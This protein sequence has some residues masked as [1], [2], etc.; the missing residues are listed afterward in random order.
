MPS[1]IMTYFKK[2]RTRA[3]YER[4]ADGNPLRHSGNNEGTPFYWGSEGFPSHEEAQKIPLIEQVYNIP[5][6]YLKLRKASVIDQILRNDPV[7]FNTDVIYAI[8]EA[9]SPICNATFDYMLK[10]FEVFKSSFIYGPGDFRMYYCGHCKE[11]SPQPFINFEHIPY[12]PKPQMEA[13]VQQR[14]RYRT[15]IYLKEKTEGTIK[16]ID[17]VCRKC[18]QSTPATMVFGVPDSPQGIELYKHHQVVDNYP[19]IQ[20]MYNTVQVTCFYGKIQFKNISSMYVFNVKTGRS[21]AMPVLRDNKKIDNKYNSMVNFT[22]GHHTPRV[23]DLHPNSAPFQDLYAA[24]SK[25]IPFGKNFA[26]MHRDAIRRPTSFTFSL[27]YFALANRFFN[28]NRPHDTRFILTAPAREKRLLSKVPRNW[29]ETIC[30]V[31]K[32]LPKQKPVRQAFYNGELGLN[33]LPRMFRWKKLITDP[34]LLVRVLSNEAVASILDSDVYYT[35]DVVRQEKSRRI[36]FLEALIAFHGQATTVKKLEQ[37]LGS[38]QRQVNN[39]FGEVTFEAEVSPQLFSDT[40]SMY[41]KLLQYNVPIPMKGSIEDMHALY[42]YVLNNIEK[43][44]RLFHF[45]EEINNFSGECAGYTFELGK[46]TNYLRA[47]GRAMNICVGGYDYQVERGHCFIVTVRKDNDLYACLEIRNS[48]HV[49]RLHAEKY[50]LVQAKHAYNRPL[51]EKFSSIV[52]AW[53]KR[54][55]IGYDQNN[56]DM[57]SKD[58]DIDRAEP[59]RFYYK[60]VEMKGQSIQQQILTLLGKG[61]PPIAPANIL[62][63]LYPQQDDYYDEDEDNNHLNPDVED[64]V[65]ILPDDRIL[66]F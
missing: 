13:E 58:D 33:S 61:N 50:Q 24:M 4:G 29:Q 41:Y 21:Y 11:A 40:A 17:Y 56:Y 66:P 3:S 18:G 49:A 57:F 22:F 31:H 60:E 38:L 44:N 63:N 62:N 9:L 46:S 51:S 14:G 25:Y 39:E 6:S 64:L 52:R 2:I 55:D 43:E 34:H 19:K 65:D 15:R 10:P 27:N 20:F 35:A 32:A 23:L 7:R 12:V 48:S 26:N 30:Y 5:E 54:R 42:S 37:G 1:S 16:P 28:I 45:P 59:K 36:K 53:A 47:V 8:R